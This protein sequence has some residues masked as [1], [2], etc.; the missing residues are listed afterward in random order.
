[1]MTPKVGPVACYAATFVL[2][3]GCS[4]GVRSTPAAAVQHHTGAG[5]IALAER[6]GVRV[7]ASAEVWPGSRRAKKLTPIRVEILNQSA[8]PLRGAFADIHLII[9]PK[10]LSARSPRDIGIEPQATTA[11]IG[12]LPSDVQAAARALEGHA[13]WAGS[14]RARPPLHRGAVTRPYWGRRAHARELLVIGGSA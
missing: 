6:E 13:R 14:S 12:A 7:A 4:N 3:L 8:R 10:Q 5:E 2:A 9:G 11:G 1:M